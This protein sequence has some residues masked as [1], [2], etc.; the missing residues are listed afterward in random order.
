MTVRDIARMHTHDRPMG[1]IQV[2]WGGSRIESW[3]SADA[4][5]SAGPPVTG[6][7]APINA[8]IAKAGA[9]VESAL[10]NG[11]V[12]PWTNFSIRAALWYQGEENADQS[13]QVNSSMWPGSAAARTQPVEYYS[14]AL[15][16]MLRDWRGSKGV[17][18]P[19]GTMQLPPSTSVRP[20]FCREYPVTCIHRLAVFIDF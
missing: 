11:M 15:S 18:F 13:C 10:F 4:L 5:A 3:M 20:A 2:A 19:L 8:P 6:N 17:N 7:V 1:L 12:S 16:A 14:V 9:N